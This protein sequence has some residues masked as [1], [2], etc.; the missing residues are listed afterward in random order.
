[1]KC[2]ICGTI[3]SANDFDVALPFCSPRCKQIDLKRWMGEE[4]SI[5]TLNLDKLE[6]EIAGVDKE[7]VREEEL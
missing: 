1:M 6:E 3:F 4:Y 2:P 7:P 5:E